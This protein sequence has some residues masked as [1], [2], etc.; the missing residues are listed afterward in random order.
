MRGE[1]KEDWRGKGPIGRKVR[2]KKEGGVGG[3]GKITSIRKGG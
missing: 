2:I 1:G 3:V